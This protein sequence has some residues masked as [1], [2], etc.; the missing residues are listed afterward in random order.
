[1][2][3]DLFVKYVRIRLVFLL[4]KKTCRLVEQEGMSSCLTRRHVFLFNRKGPD[5]QGNPLERCAGKNAMGAMAFFQGPD[6]K[7]IPW[8]MC[9]QKKPWAPWHFSKAP[10]CHGHLFALALM[11]L[12]TPFCHGPN[13]I[14]PCRYLQNGIMQ[15]P[16]RGHKNL[17]SDHLHRRKR[18]RRSQRWMWTTMRS[19]L[20]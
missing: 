1:M 13:G 11:V 9:G 18:K 15:Q 8:Q 10:F 12:F 19:L 5:L 17:L 14:F 7:G 6:P 16:R 20:K 2:D 4:N 3:R